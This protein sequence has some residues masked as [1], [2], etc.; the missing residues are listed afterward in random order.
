[1]RPF[2]PGRHDQRKADAL[3][4]GIILV[5]MLVLDISA[6]VIA[7][8]AVRSCEQALRPAQNLLIGEQALF[9][10]RSVFTHL[11]IKIRL[12]QKDISITFSLSKLISDAQRRK[13]HQPRQKAAGRQPCPQK[14]AFFFYA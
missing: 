4:S 8:H 13:Q 6:K 2:L 11:E 7:S 3:Y 14:T 5:K 10:I 1:M 12:Q 9:D